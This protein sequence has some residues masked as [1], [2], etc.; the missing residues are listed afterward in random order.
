MGS[1]ANTHS[2]YVSSLPVAQIPSVSA[3]MDEPAIEQWCN[4]SQF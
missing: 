4:R 1:S 3:S 2:A